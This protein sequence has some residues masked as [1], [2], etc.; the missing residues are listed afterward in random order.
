MVETTN[1]MRVLSGQITSA[2]RLYFN[3]RNVDISNA[4]D[5]IAL[6]IFA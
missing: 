4:A 6:L 1:A 3:M 5:C 2:L